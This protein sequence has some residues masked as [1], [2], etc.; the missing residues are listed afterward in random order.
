MTVL[1]TAGLFRRQPGF[2][3]AAF[4][5]EE[6]TCP[7][8]PDVVVFFLTALQIGYSHHSPQ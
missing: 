8:L 5:R 2:T 6:V 7:P 1:G 4:P 3:E